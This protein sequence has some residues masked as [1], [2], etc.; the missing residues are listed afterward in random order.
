MEE[1][2]LRFLAWPL[3]GQ[4]LNPVIGDQIHLGLQVFGQSRQRFDLVQPVIHSGNQDIFEGDH[5]ASLFLKVLA[6]RSQ[7]AQRILAIY[8]HNFAARFVGP[9]VQR[10]RQPQLQRL[11]RK[12]PN[13]RRQAAGR[14]RDLPRADASAPGR[15]ENFERLH[16]I[17]VI[18]Q[19]LPHP[20]DNQVA[21]QTW[22]KC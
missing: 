1:T 12:F 2:F 9:S 20:H 10:H 19:R 21:D 4:P 3:P 5:P 17:L 14:D 8:R 11:V 16:Q 6:S 18:G 7:F 22:G 13:L 15:V